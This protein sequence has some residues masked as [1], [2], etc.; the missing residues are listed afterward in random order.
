MLI[1]ASGSPYRKKQLSDLGLDF[2]AVKPSLDED[3]LK[4]SWVGKNKGKMTLEKSKKLAA[5]LACEKAKSLARDGAIVIG[6]DQ[7]AF[8]GGE[9][10]G[11][12][13]SFERAFSQ[14]K[15]M[16]GRTHSLVTAVSLSYGRG[17]TVTKVVVAQVKMVKASDQEIKRMLEF[18]QP[19]D[20]AGAYKLESAGPMLIESIRVSDLT[21]IVGLPVLTTLELL[22]KIKAP[23]VFK[24]RD[25][26]E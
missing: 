5:H 10:L 15:R 9:I 22:R 13:G 7:L 3:A 11:K 2:E 14:L 24:K 4:A 17:K 19:Y 23:L 16:R 20:C 12:P 25:E 8:F 1:L 26:N 21:S 18:D 6:S